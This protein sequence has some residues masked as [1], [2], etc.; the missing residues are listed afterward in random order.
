M[1]P[2]DPAFRFSRIVPRE[3]AGPQLDEPTLREIAAAMT[4]G[5]EP[6]DWSLH[7]P[8]MANQSGL[9]RQR[10]VEIGD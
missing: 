2:V 8:V 7:E 6:V 4:A 5:G 1:V 10:S 9:E 3:R